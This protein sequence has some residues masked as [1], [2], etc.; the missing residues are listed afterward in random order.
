[1]FQRDYLLR[2]IEAGAQA[3]ARARRRLAEKRQDE[4]EQ[5]LAE[6]YAAL[7]LDRELLFLLDARS[8][9]SQLVDEEKL[10]MA[11]QLLICDAEV[12]LHRSAPTAASRRLKA[13]S[14]LLAEHGPGAALQELSNELARVHALLAEHP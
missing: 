6:G 9:K 4:A 1:V 10:G 13:A 14:R 2:M 5:E 7:G 8:L 3:I 12:Q 11:A